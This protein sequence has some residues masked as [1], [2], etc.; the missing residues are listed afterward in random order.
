MKQIMTASILGAALASCGTAEETKPFEPKPVEVSEGRLTSEILWQLARVG[1]AQVSPDGQTVVFGVTYT[2]IA[3]NRNF[4]DVYSIK[5]G[6]KEP[7]RL[8]RTVANEMQV[9]WTPDGR[10]IAYM[11][12]VD[13]DAQLWLMNPDGSNQTQVTNIEGGISGYIFAPDMSHVAYTRS[14]KLDTLMSEK[15]PDMPKTTARLETDLMYRHWNKWADGKYSHVCIANFGVNSVGE[16]VD[17]MEGERYHSPLPPFGGMEQICF[18]PDGQK[19]IYTCK[20]LTG[21]AAARSTD[22]GLYEYDLQTKQTRLLTEGMHGYDTNPQ[23][24]ADGSRLFWLSMEHAGYESD[25]NRLMMRDLATGETVELTDRTEDHVNAFSPS[26]DG[27]TVWFVANHKGCDR[28]FGVDIESHEIKCITPNDTCDYTSIAETADGL[29]VVNRMSMKAPSEI[30]TID[31]SVGKAEALTAM[32]EA[33]LSQVKMG[34]IEERWMTTT[35]QKQ[36]HTWII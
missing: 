3:A 11:A 19:L 2:D 4:T 35:D 26:K 10:K 30:F 16:E 31:P 5:T 1:E 29:L 9:S 27:R 32:N 12:A 36:M 21:M 14:V 33:T 17:I 7:V 18:S 20:K 25:K 34:N 15:Y 23:Y 8:T 24:S 13:K 28:V 6:D 22:S